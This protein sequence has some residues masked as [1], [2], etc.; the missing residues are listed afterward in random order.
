MGFWWEFY[1]EGFVRFCFFEGLKEVRDALR[2]NE[3]L[4][5]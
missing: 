5:A 1:Q 3:Q 4:L 2:A